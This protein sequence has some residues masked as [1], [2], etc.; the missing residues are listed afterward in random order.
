[1]VSTTYNKYKY[2]YYDI[3]IDYL[4]ICLNESVL[5]PHTT[6]ILQIFDRSAYFL[7]FYSEAIKGDEEIVNSIIDGPKTL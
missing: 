3:S 7:T 2:L 1:M 6:I 5:C 4:S